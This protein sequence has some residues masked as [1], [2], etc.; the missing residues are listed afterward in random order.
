MA[1]KAFT[2]IELLVVIAIIAILAS[3]LFPVLA[4]ARERA[5]RA[6]CISNLRQLG[7]AVAQYTDDYDGRFPWAYR[8]IAVIWDHS[9]SIAD[10]M[11]GY[12][13][14]HDLWRCPSD[15]G[16]IYLHDPG[17]WH[18]HTLP[19]YKFAEA[20]YE[21]PG[22]GW[23]LLSGHLSDERTVF[24]IRKPSQTVLLSEI[25]P[26]HGPYRTDEM[27]W[28]SLGWYNVLYVDGHVQRRTVRE[29][30]RDYET[31]FRW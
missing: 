26:W 17:T 16:E 12:V 10:A 7:T 6:H 1:R 2:L 30:Y 18:D 3:L 25:R 13:T 23:P 29:R 4:K 9:P 15:I 5:R 14:S 19:M 28:D 11:T 31:A 27:W 24:R 22:E 21:Y 20:S 8:S